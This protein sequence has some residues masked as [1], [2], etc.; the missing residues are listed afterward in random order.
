MANNDITLI[1]PVHDLENNAEKEFLNNAL[2][3][4]STQWELP[5]KVMLVIDGNNEELKN[6]INNEIECPDNVKEILSVVENDTGNTY[7]QAQMNFAVSKVDTTW[8]SF[9]ELD[10]ELSAP[11]I[12]NVSKYKGVYDDVDM[13]LPII[14]DTEL[15]ENK[16]QGG[17]QDD[18]RGFTN[19]AVWANE[20]SDERGILDNNALLNYRNFNF[21]GMAMKKEVYE[22]LGGIKENMKLTFMYEF[23][24][25]M[26]YN[27]VR[28]MTIPKF[29]YKH[30]NQRENSLFQKY[31]E[32]MRPDEANWWLSMAE[33]EYFF[34]KDREISY[35][36]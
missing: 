12:K 1:I 15:T 24:L 6:T 21:D 19:E 20:F 32:S 3:S 4:V 25:R 17:L 28:I 16:E 2:N 8:F 9:L 36:E 22:D 13:F 7:F 29:G 11:Y 35:D 33:S 27:D 31:K 23:L 10:D 30:R 18:F 5:E 34:T 26:T 14:V